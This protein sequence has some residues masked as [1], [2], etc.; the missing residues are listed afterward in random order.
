MISFTLCGIGGSA[1]LSTRASGQQS[2]NK[3]LLIIFGIA[4]L[5]IAA[6]YYYYNVYLTPKPQMK[7]FEDAAI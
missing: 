7:N 2:E 1:C 5:I 6:S 3:L 4:I